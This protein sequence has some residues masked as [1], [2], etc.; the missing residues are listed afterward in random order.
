[1]KNVAHIL[2]SKPSMT[3][4]SVTSTSSMYDAIKLMAEKN[5]GAVLVI[6]GGTVKGIVSERDYARKIVLTGRAS[7]ETPVGDVMSSPVISVK[8]ETNTEECMAMMTGRR[9]RHLP[10]MDGGQLVGMVS[11]GDLVKDIISEQTYMIEQL[12][13]YISGRSA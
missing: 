11:I 1:M 4:H 10:V 2:Q 7:R 3:V 8:P 13:D 9:L 5:I 6:D 12:Q